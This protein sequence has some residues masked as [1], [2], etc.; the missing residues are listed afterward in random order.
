MSP[1]SKDNEVLTAPDSAAAVPPASGTRADDTASRPQAVALEVPVTVNGARTVE[2]SDKREPFSETTKT[3]LVFGGGAVIRLGSPVAPGQLLFLTN[4]KTKKEVVCQVVNSK[5]Y[6]N[7]SGY[8]ELEFTESVVG[9]WGMRFPSDRSASHPSAPSVLAPPSSKGLPAS[10]ISVTSSSAS[11]V[12]SSP[13]AVAPEISGFKSAQIAT[14]TKVTAPAVS[15]PEISPLQITAVPAP[16][17]TMKPERPASIAP[18]IPSEKKTA[19]VIAAEGSSEALKPE[20]A[21]LQEQLSSLIFNPA[22]PAKVALP[23]A[24]PDSKNVSGLAA[25][26]LK[27]AKPDP[28]PVKTPSLARPVPP[29]IKS[30]L[31]MEEVK[32]PSWLEPLARNAAIHAP[33]PELNELEKSNRVVEDS[34]VEEPLAET[35]STREVA[36]ETEARL[37]AFGSLLAFDERAAS[38]ELPSHGSRKGLWIGVTAAVMLLTA[39]AAW[40]QFYPSNVLQAPAPP[41]SQAASIQPAGA[42]PEQP[43]VR[44]ADH[45]AAQNEEA[46]PE[47]ASRSLGVTRSSS[48]AT[49]E[50]QAK[51]RA[52]TEST[53]N[54]RDNTRS[55]ATTIPAAITERIPRS[56]STPQSEPK[57]P[58]LGPVHLATPTMNRTDTT[59][60]DDVVAPT[61]SR[62]SV[63]ASVE[64]FDSGLAA[65]KSEQPA[66]PEVPLPIGGEVTPA[67]LISHVAPMY[68]LMAK[69][70][71]VSGDV[72]IDALIDV[73]GRV[74]T[75]KVISGPALLHQ[76][77]KDALHQWKYQPASL[78]G[79]PVPMHLSVTLQ[80]RMQ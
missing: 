41:V 48:A 6:R 11:K 43:E 80:F 34:V 73:N 20:T 2:G 72:V 54:T 60:R 38:R 78:D 47:S 63:S 16:P 56:A 33:T 68:P 44:S 66:A 65:G 70:Q 31:D 75:M 35:A 7:V 26:I 46:S 45:R 30:A 8:V 5:N 50:P 76:A 4:E 29:P 69:N 52:G 12:V 3:V 27:M 57:R 32:I 59:Q 64:G 37:P 55:S 40:Y 71:H 42:Q 49:S 62:G 10:P 17:S 13:V 19:P 23:V 18:S 28:I 79:K 36:S 39:G 22:P 9:F 58:A 25:E 15:K 51:S 61:L 1:I 77:A 24:E 74:T 53:P 67:R 21:R 14:E